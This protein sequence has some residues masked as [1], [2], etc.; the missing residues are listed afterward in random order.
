MITKDE[1]KELL[2]VLNYYLIAGLSMGI[3]SA[4]VAVIGGILVV[5]SNYGLPLP[6]K[7]VSSIIVILIGVMTA[8]FAYLVLLPAELRVVRRKL[9]PILLAKRLSG[10]K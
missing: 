4:S 8:L 1:F 5:K 10:K 7:A 6:V 2:S 9:Q 3:V